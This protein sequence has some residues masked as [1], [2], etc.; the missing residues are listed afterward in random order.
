MA[1]SVSIMIFCIIARAAVAY[2]EDAIADITRVARRGFNHIVCP[3]AKQDERVDIRVDQRLSQV[4][5]RHEVV[6]V[7]AE[8]M[9]PDRDAVAP[10]RELPG[11]QDR[12]RHE[13]SEAD[14]AL[15][16]GVAVLV[17][18]AAVLLDGT[19]G[20]RPDRRGGGP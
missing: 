16:N 11:R 9:L 18:Q 4:R 13:V 20:H 7:D 14:L 1:C 3:E 5:V 8:R 12:P 2:D 6:V 10:V 17:E 19:H 15:A